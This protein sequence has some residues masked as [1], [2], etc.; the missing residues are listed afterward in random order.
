M[1]YALG[2]LTVF[3]VAP[4]LLWLGQ[5]IT[6]AALGQVFFLCWAVPFLYCVAKSL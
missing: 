6:I 3:V 4:F 2:G 1:K 5:A